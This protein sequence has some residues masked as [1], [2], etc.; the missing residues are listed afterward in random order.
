M[1]DNVD[2]LKDMIHHAVDEKPLDFQ[3]KFNSM[4]VDRIADAINNKKIEVAQSMFSSETESESEEE[5][6]T[7]DSTDEDS[8]E[9]LESDT[10]E[11]QENGEES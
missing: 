4:L 11:T 7:E 1:T 5:V 9:E 3:D 6:S 2:T 10:E 8:T